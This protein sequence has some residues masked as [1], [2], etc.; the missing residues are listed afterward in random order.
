MVQQVPNGFFVADG[1]EWKE[2]IKY[3][4]PEDADSGL[5]SLQLTQ[6]GRNQYT[7]TFVV[8]PR[9]NQNF[10]DKNIL[11]MVNTDQLSNNGYQSL[12]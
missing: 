11:A 3:K 10:N 4:I 1:L 2:T 12:G 5:Y 8:Q 6:E 7:I 9:L